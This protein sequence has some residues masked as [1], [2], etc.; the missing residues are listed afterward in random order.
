MEPVQ[1]GENEI[2]TI[3][4]LLYLRSDA[5]NSF[6]ESLRAWAGI[7]LGLALITLFVCILL[8]CTLLIRLGWDAFSLP[9]PDYQNAS[10]NFLLAFA[11]A[12]GA[13]LLVWRAWLAHRQALAATQQARVAAEN[14]ITG[15]FV[16]SVELL[17]FA[18]EIKTT[19]TDGAPVVRSLPNLESRLGALYSLERLLR[20]SKKDERAILETLCA[21]V[22]EN[23]PA[24]LP[25]DKEEAKRI[26]RG[27]TPMLPTRRS[28]VQAALT[29][30]GRRSESIRTR[31]AEER[32][33]LDFRNANLVAYDFSKLNFDRSDFSG[34]FLVGA[35]MSEASFAHGI[36]SGSVL[37]D[38][39]LRHSHFND[40]FFEHCDLKNAQIENSNFRF[41]TIIDADLREAKITSF[42]I[43]GTNLEKAF[44]YSLEYAVKSIKTDGAT[45][46]N[47]DE[48]VRVDQLFQKAVYDQQTTVSQATR[49]AIEMMVNTH[50]KQP[51]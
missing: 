28:D 26:F 11:S 49:D 24:Q 30:I 43:R 50:I 19:G 36:F 7:I 6:L 39:D 48:I 17:G 44:S 34:S 51:A 46:F 13:P 5:A 22:R 21:Y 3:W 4:D 45:R 23:S 10:R 16:K 38:S 42:D 12:F 40:S 27:D 33:N 2:K 31:A 20:E 37:R 14:H 18:R 1:R 41:S 29:I 35:K 15:I 9:S 25:E 32:W 8:T 47:S